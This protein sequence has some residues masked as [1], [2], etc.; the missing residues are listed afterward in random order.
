VIKLQTLTGIVCLAICAFAA[1]GNGNGSGIA[2]ASNGLDKAPADA[3]GKVIH[4][5][6]DAALT[7]STTSGI[8]YHGG[9]VMLGTPT[10]YYIW[11]GTWSDNSP[12]ILQNLAQTIGGSPYF[13]INTTYS[14]YSGTVSGAV[15][16]VATQSTT[17]RRAR[18]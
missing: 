10:V 5:T 4:P 15:A 6:R 13:H 2:N 1:D 16:W 3:S 12:T 14:S 17:T 9:A 8:Q 7:S 11:Y 18:A